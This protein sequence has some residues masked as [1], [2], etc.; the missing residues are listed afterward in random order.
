MSDSTFFVSEAALRNLKLNAQHGVSGISSSH[1]SESI[2]TALGFKTHAAL[3]A[4]LAGHATAEVQKPNNAQLVQRLQALGYAVPDNLHL[5]PEFKET[6]TP[7]KAYPLRKKRGVRWWAWRNLMVSAIN[8]G[9]EQRLF[10]L[11]PDENWWPGAVPEEGERGI[12]HFVFDREFP[13]MAS[14]DAVRGD[15]LSISVVLRPKKPDVV[16]MWYSSFGSGDAV[17]HG[18]LERRMGSWIQDGG[19]DFR[20]RRA[21]Q[22]RVADALITSAGFAD[23]GAFFL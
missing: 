1:L 8:A 21:L 20:C 4:A 13:A 12:Y 18:W 7:F 3:R 14:V 11:S 22:S 15:E 16:P 6:I 23:Q 19:E 10:G 2:A 17:A 5:L 9:L